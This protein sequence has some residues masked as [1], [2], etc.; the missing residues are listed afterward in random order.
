[1]SCMSCSSYWMVW[2]MGGK[3]LYSC[4][5]GGVASRNCTTCTIHALLPSRFSMRFVGVHVMHLWNC[6]DTT[7]AR[8]KSGFILSDIS[9]FH[10]IDSLSR[11]VH[12]FARRML[13][14]FSVDWTLL[15]G[16][17]NWSTN[18]KTLPFTILIAPS[19]FK[20]SNIYIYIYI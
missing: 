10:I 16:Y 3:W 20:W 18:F 4:Y 17:V 6:I 14:A 15:R 7:T 9:D 8:K 5:F 1:M 11:A 12:A 13:T 2:G 19:R